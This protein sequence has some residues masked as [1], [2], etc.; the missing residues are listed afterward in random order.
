MEELMAKRWKD[1]CYA[2]V[3]CLVDICDH[4]IHEIV[5]NETLYEVARDE[6][7]TVVSALVDYFYNGG[8]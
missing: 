3:K 4:P 5:E 1:A 8:K 6:N 7:P 2:A